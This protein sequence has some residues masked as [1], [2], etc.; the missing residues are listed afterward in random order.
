MIRKILL[1]VI[2]AAGLALPGCDYSS[3]EPGQPPTLPPQGGE[4]PRVQSMLLRGG[5]LSRVQ[6]NQ[7]LECQEA[8]KSESA[9]FTTL[10]E[11]ELDACLDETLAVQLGF[12][13]G[14]LDATHYNVGL[15]Q[16]RRDCAR[17][18]KEIGAASTLLVDSIIAACKPVQ[19]IILPSQGYDPLQFGVLARVQNITLS[20]AAGLAGSICGAKELVVDTSVS[21][22][23]PRM[24]GLLKIL[25]QGTGQ[26]AVAGPPSATLSLTPI[27]PN[28]P[29]DARC[30]LPAALP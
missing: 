23:V 8:L 22:Q 13:N 30:V 6:V 1:T 17:R 12:E 3:I 11:K 24:V 25:D 26:F 10:K 7:V 20:D 14:Q 21:L 16:A 18:F 27:I 29:L 28:I 9:E 15:A 4:S 5:L 19:N 2:L